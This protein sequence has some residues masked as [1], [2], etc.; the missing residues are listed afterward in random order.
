MRL[1]IATTACLIFGLILLLSWPWW[2]GAKP[3]DDASRQDLARYGLRML[4]Y[5]GVTSLTFIAAAVLALFVAR[6]TKDAYRTEA[7]SNLKDLVEGSIEDHGG[8]S[9]RES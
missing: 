7:M 1:K 4:S 3:D 8:R 6:Q 5:F 2:V 9:S